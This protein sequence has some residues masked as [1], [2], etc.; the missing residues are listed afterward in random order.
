MDMDKG[1]S[2][3][4]GLLNEPSI[5]CAKQ[6]V[7]KGSIFPQHTHNQKE[8]LIVYEGEMLLE[9]EG[10]QYVLGIGGCIYINPGVEHGATFSSD[11]WFIAIT[12]PQTEGWPQALKGE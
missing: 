6:F 2:L 7:S 8:F 4:F 5:S 1:T 11:C 10:N 12:I 3:M 9:M